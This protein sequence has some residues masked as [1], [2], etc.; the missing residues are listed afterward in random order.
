MLSGSLSDGDLFPG[1]CCQSGQHI[2]VTDQVFVHRIGR[3][4]VWPANDK[5]NPV[6]ALVTIGLHASQW[7]RA[8]MSQTLR[9]GGI[10]TGPLSLVN[11]SSVSSAILC[12]SSRFMI[13]PTMSS[14]IIT[15]SPYILALLFPLEP[16]TGKPGGV[17]RGAA[18]RGRR[19]FGIPAVIVPAYLGISLL[20]VILLAV[21][22]HVQIQERLVPCQNAP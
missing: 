19:V 20:V 10:Q 13:W 1:Q 7:A 14:T 12:C 17:E 4:L 9:V 3:C 22:R 11:M 21:P 15:K 5:W 16:F 8:T 18:D 6:A 2:G